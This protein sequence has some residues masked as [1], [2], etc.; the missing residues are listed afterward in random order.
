MTTH[1][2]VNFCLLTNKW[3]RLSIQKNWYLASLDAYSKNKNHFLLKG[4]MQHNTCRAL[5]TKV[6]WENKS[7]VV[8]SV[9]ANSPYSQVHSNNNIDL[10]FLYVLLQLCI[11]II[12]NGLF[13]IINEWSFWNIR[14]MK[15]HY[16]I[17]FYY[18]SYI[19]LVCTL[20]ISFFC[21]D[22]NTVVENS[23]PSCNCQIFILLRALM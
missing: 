22:K 9:I 11:S 3:T 17:N 14:W 21:F 12:H 6:I 20:I 10:Q 8:T 23:L 4:I 13:S 1:I 18:E 2:V 15:N 19:R 16:P 5:H 7:Y